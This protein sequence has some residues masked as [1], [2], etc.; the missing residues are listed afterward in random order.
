MAQ[1]RKKPTGLKRFCD[2]RLCLKMSLSCNRGLIKAKCPLFAVGLWVFAMLEVFFRF[3]QTASQVNDPS[4]LSGIAT[5]MAAEH[6]LCLWGEYRCWQIEVLTYNSRGGGRS[7][8]LWTQI[9]RET[10]FVWELSQLLC[11]LPEVSHLSVFSD[12]L[13]YCSLLG[14]SFKYFWRRKKLVIGLFCFTSISEP[15]SDSHLVK[16]VKRSKK[17]TAF[18]TQIIYFKFSS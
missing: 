6:V 7:G 12:M 14:S 17:Q 18:L 16:N 8:E 11:W 15:P 10:F 9:W 3:G 5:E 2:V 4:S 1:W 13:V